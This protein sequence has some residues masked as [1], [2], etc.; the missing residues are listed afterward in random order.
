MFI[1]LL[2]ES[3]YVRDWKKK[4]RGERSSTFT[5]YRQLPYYLELNHIKL[6]QNSERNE[7]HFAAVRTNVTT[8]TGRPVSS[9][10]LLSSHFTCNTGIIIIIIITTLV[11][12]SHISTEA[13][14]TMKTQ[15]EHRST[16]QLSLNLRF[17]SLNT[18]I[19]W[20]SNKPWKGPYHTN[21]VAYI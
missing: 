9:Q 20:N 17:N 6:N 3:I 14:I 19:S 8:E 21:P 13:I 11:L 15:T 2:W 18:W 5:R 4:E 7:G 1:R 12:K 16:T 10:A